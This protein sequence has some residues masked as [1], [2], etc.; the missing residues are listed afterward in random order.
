[1]KH[2]YTIAMA[3]TLLLLLASCGS[4]APVAPSQ[5]DALNKIS[6]S[7]GKEKSSYMQQGLDTWLEEEWEPAVEKDKEIQ[8]KYMEKVQGVAPKITTKEEL[9]KN[10]TSNLSKKVQTEE[11]YVEKTNKPFT[12]QEY[13]D[14]AAAYNKQRQKKDLEDSHSEKMKKMPVIG[15]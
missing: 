11:K 15:E 3:Q 12:L 4:S 14:K 7:K 10:S 13:V 9:E 2:L 8:N 5:N 1:M 6:N